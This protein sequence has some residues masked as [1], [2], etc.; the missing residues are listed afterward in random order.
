M[1]GSGYLEMARCFNVHR[2]LPVSKKLSCLST[3]RTWLKLDAP[4]KKAIF[5]VPV[6]QV[7]ELKSLTGTI[8]LS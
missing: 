8:T 2:Q 7:Y 4:V 6:Y 5:N 1:H 3:E